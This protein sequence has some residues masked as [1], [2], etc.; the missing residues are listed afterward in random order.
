MADLRQLA[1]EFVLA[2]DEL[3]QTK[4]AQQAATGKL[5]TALKYGGEASPV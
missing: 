4:L 2:D 3:K 5:F 1:L